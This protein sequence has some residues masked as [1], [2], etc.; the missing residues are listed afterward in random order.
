MLNFSRF[1]FIK[2]ESMKK[3]LLLFSLLF[4]FTF[5]QAQECEPDLS[6][7][8]STAGV[9]PIPNEIVCNNQSFELVLTVVVTETIELFGST[10]DL[11][12]IR[13]VNISG[14]PNGISFAC[15]PSSC[16]F[17]SNSIGCAIASGT[18]NDALGEYPLS[19][20]VEVF[21]NG[22]SV[23]IEAGFPLPTDTNVYAL[24]LV[25]ENDPNCLQ[26]PTNDWLRSQVSFEAMPNPTNGLTTI[27]LTSRLTG[28]MTFSISNMMGQQVFTNAIQV[29]E[30]EN[31]FDVDATDFANGIYLM[32]IT[33][34]NQT[35]SKK[36]VVNK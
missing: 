36:L 28:D 4:A 15:N 2:I 30:G 8:D 25:E 3:L 16:L 29:F 22:G 27:E 33:K 21:I 1:L 14:L 6:F 5:T 7:Q 19:I 12:S 31:R 26:N 20:D 13:V 34:E 32:S 11:D 35:I 9:Y 24:T 10:F 23:P 18:P 17:V